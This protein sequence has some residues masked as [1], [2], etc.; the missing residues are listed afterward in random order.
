ME[1]PK[2]KLVFLGDVFVGKTSI[3]KQFMSESFDSS[4]SATVGIDFLS[5][6]MH[7]G[8]RTIRLQLWDT[9]GQERFRSLIPNYIRDSA[10]AII[11]FD[12]C[13]SESFANIDTWISDVKAE[14]GDQALIV[15]VGN[16]VDKEDERTVDSGEAESKA[17]ELQIPYIETSAQTGHNVQ[18]LFKM[19]S[20]MLPEE[21]APPPEDKVSPVKISEKQ[22]PSTSQKC[23]C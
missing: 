21:Q 11:V 23:N 3:I 9:A 4:Y 15:L 22:P 20:R 17:Q 18:Q 13:S 19:V 7:L 1:I 16:K 14:R 12:I 8:D 6:N 5:K 2:Y 10:A